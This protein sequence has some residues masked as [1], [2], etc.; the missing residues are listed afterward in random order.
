MF[1][2]IALQAIWL[3]NV[4]QFKSQELTDKTRDAILQ[5][6]KRLQKEEDSKLILQN[7]DSLLVTDNIIG[8]DTK[9]DMRVIVS[10]IKII[11]NVI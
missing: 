2:L 6:I 8:S 7:I 11:F 3:F 4:Y 1:G 10:N 5:T 9:S